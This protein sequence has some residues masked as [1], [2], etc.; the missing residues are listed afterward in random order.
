MM[1]DTKRSMTEAD[2]LLQA[3]RQERVK[4][5]ESL[6]ERILADAELVRVGWDAVAAGPQPRESRWTRIRNLLG[7]WPGLGGM[8][9]T[10]ALGLWLGIAPPG[11]VPDPVDM[12]VGQTAELDLFDSYD[13]ASALGGE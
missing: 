2:R 5:P 7:G 13:L 9:A 12:V 8:A 10:C 1:N 3:A 11:F 4:M 6:S